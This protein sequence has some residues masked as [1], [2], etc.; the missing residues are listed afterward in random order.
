MLRKL[1]KV[2]GGFARD[3]KLAA[4]GAVIVILFVVTGLFAEQLAPKDPNRVSVRTR[5]RPPAPSSRW[6][7]T[8]TAATCSAASSSAPACRSTCR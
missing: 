8:T 5:W 4:I 1:L 7:P 3:H 2:I 6:A